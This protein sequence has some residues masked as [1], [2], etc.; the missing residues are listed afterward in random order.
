MGKSRSAPSA[1]TGSAAAC[2]HHEKEDQQKVVPNEAQQADWD[3]AELSQ[4]RSPDIGDSTNS[5]YG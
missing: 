2:L 3:R 4:S 5:K 1:S